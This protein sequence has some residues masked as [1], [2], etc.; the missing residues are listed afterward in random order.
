MLPSPH[1][2][3][4]LSKPDTPPRP[5]SWA[6]TPPQKRTDAR[7]SRV[8]R[9][10]V[11]DVTAAVQDG[12]TQEEEEETGES[13]LVGVFRRNLAFMSLFDGDLPLC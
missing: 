3:F 10:G 11:S 2:L 8:G 4:F 5:F 13:S 6:P 1:K 9:E 12:A 7:A